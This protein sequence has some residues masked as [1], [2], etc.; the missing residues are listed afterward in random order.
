MSGTLGELSAVGG[1]GGQTIVQHPDDAEW[2]NLSLNA[3]GAVQGNY[4]VPLR[5]ARVLEA[6]KLVKT[7]KTY[8]LGII[9]DS[10]MPSYPPRTCS[11]GWGIVSTFAGEA[12][13]APRD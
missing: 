13:E 5:S 1:H 11:I 4:L 9:V 2:P 12:H 8:S 7:G 3:L 6:A 10:K